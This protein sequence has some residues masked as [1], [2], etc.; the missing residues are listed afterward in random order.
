[1]AVGIVIVL[2][3]ASDSDDD[4]ASDLRNKSPALISLLSATGYTP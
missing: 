4:P 3:E 1:V 2:N